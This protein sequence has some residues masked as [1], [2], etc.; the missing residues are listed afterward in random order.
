MLYNKPLQQ[1]VE[2]LCARFARSYLIRLQLNGG[3]K[4]AN[5]YG[6]TGTRQ[7]I[8]SKQRKGFYEPLI[9]PSAGMLPRDLTGVTGTHRDTGTN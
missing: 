7:R 5:V 3:V 4:P 2:L 9:A 8:G 6:K 1:T